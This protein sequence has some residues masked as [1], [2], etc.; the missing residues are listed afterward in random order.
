[1]IVL[2]CIYFYYWKLGEDLTNQVIEYMC[3][4]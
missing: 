2:L 4:G 1:M 3:S